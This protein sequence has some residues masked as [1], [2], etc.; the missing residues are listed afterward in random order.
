MQTSLPVSATPP[1]PR[2][3]SAAEEFAPRVVPARLGQQVP[4][5]RKIS[6]HGIASTAFGGTSFGTAS[7]AM[8]EVYSLIAR[9]APTDVTLALIGETGTGKDVFAHLVHDFSPRA[10]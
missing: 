10:R 2:V 6:P 7:P 8:G 1:H 3:V 5:S 4:T 9:L